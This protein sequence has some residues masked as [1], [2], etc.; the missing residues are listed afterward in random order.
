M[1][2][3]LPQAIV[4]GSMRMAEGVMSAG[5]T[6]LVGLAVAAGAR[7]VRGDVRAG[8]IHL[9]GAADLDAGVLGRQE[10][11]QGARDVDLVGRHR[12]GHR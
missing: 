4:G 9:L 8:V 7:P 11:A 10:H 3:W 12:L 2:D 6:L 1:S 5:P